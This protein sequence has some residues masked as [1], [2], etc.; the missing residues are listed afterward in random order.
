MLS[1]NIQYTKTYSIKVIET[2]S[3]DAMPMAHN[4]IIEESE[5]EINDTHEIF[6][7]VTNKHQ[8]DKY[9]VIVKNKS[10][11]YI[12]FNSNT[13]IAKLRVVQNNSLNQISFNTGFQC[14]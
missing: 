5:G 14:K 3:Q 2:Y 7:S 4:F 13:E 1:S 8:A 10:N 9:F 6:P 12:S 11:N